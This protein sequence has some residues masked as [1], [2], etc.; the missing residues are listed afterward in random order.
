MTSTTVVIAAAGRGSRLSSNV[1]KALFPL[2]HD[3]TTM[4]EHQVGKFISLGLSA[5]PVVSPGVLSA[6]GQGHKL[7]SSVYVQEIPTGMG[8]ALFSA[9]DVI[10]G[11]E[12]VLFTWVDQLG[13]TTDTISAALRGLGT[14]NRRYVV[15]CLSKEESYTGLDW[16]ETGVSAAYESREGDVVPQD[17]VSDVGL[18][19]FTDGAK[20]VAEWDEF[21]LTGNRGAITGEINFLKFLPWL[22]KKGWLGQQIDAKPTDGLSVNTPEELEAWRDNKHA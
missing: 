7:S 4:L 19:A 3:G 21:R 9:R 13:L 14:S 12:R 20:L 2:D 5:Y 10:A 15:P 22:T 16:G 1:P 11:S 17:V 8:D 18:F 6:L